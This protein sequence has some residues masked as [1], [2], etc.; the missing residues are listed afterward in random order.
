MKAAEGGTIRGSGSHTRYNN[1]NRTIQIRSTNGKLGEQRAELTVVEA[2]EKDLHAQI[3]QL[4]HSGGTFSPELLKARDTVEGELLAGRFEELIASDA[5]LYEALLGPL[6][7][8]IAVE[9]I[10]PEA[11]SGLDSLCRVDGLKGIVS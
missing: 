7:Q 5:A 1:G 2:R 8:A 9:D 10:G 6:A 11:A 3:T 4:E